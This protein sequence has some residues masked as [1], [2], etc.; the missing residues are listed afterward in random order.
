[1]K[2][3]IARIKTII[4]NVYDENYK[5]PKLTITEFMNKVLDRLEKE[6]EPPIKDSRNLNRS[7]L[8]EL[9]SNSKKDTDKQINEISKFIDFI[10]I[11]LTYMI[12]EQRMEDGKTIFIINIETYNSIKKYIKL[13]QAFASI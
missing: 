3:S 4:L 2:L 1:M 11:R 10:D 8:I 7:E 12:S 13:I 9:I 6:Y 5:N